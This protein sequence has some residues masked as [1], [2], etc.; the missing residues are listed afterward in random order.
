VDVDK[1]VKDL[2]T[3]EGDL[4]KL[5][6]KGTAIPYLQKMIEASVE[7]MLVTEWDE[8]VRNPQANVLSTSHPHG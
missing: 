7:A 1:I 2:Y 8:S 5:R 6:P 4:Y 3:H